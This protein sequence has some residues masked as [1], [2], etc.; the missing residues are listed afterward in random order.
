MHRMRRFE[1]RLD[2]VLSVRIQQEKIQQKEFA[3]VQA[4]YQKA[5]EMLKQLFDSRQETVL[6]L[7][8]LSSKGFDQRVYLAHMSFIEKLNR[9]IDMQRIT[10]QKIEVELNKERKKLLEAMQ[11]RKILEIL[12]DKNKTEYIHELLIEEQ[13]VL[14]DLAKNKQAI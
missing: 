5:V 10:L 11:K 4:K 2:R 14:D 3:V 7:K 1:F 8:K 13:K 9:D 6:N 12:K